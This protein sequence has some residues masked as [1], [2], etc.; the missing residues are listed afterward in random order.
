MQIHNVIE[1]DI[2]KNY[3]ILILSV[4]P[5]SIFICGIFTWLFET[6]FNFLSIF[7][8]LK[9]IVLTPTTLYTDFLEV[10]GISAALIN[11][12][13]IGFYNLFLLWKYKLRI[14]GLLIAAFLTVI[15][16]SFF[17]KNLFNI[18]PIYIGGYLYSKYQNI[19]FKDI[20]L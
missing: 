19:E 7:T 3:K 10:G 14:N 2:G 17:G 18:F 1:K 5:V 8:G 20:I 11:A 9:H 16:F 15:G 4:F 6:H 12:S 13:L